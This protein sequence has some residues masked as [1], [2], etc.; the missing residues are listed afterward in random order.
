MIDQQDFIELGT[1]CKTY[2]SIS[3]PL[4]LRKGAMGTLPIPA[5]RLSGTRKGPMYVRKSDLDGW[6]AERIAKAE[7][8]NSK[9]RLAGAV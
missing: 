9:M 3:A 6:V 5:F 4:A 8:L 1:V 2:F 7:K